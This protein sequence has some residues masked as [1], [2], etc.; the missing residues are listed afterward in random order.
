MYTDICTYIMHIQSDNQKGKLYV[1]LHIMHSIA[2]YTI[3]CTSRS[4]V[5]LQMV[6]YKHH[7]T[8]LER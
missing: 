4:T 2:F 1:S 3:L 8:D 7:S 6:V 5:G